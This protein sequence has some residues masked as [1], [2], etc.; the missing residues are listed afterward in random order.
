MSGTNGGNEGLRY[1]LQG[2][3][4][5]G[6][7]GFMSGPYCSMLLADMGAEVIK[8]EQPGTG[9]PRRSIHPFAY[10]EDGRRLAA[11]FWA[12]NRNK[13]SMTLNLRTD[14]GKKALVDLV[15]AS[16]V[17]VENLR[18]GA[19][20]K[21]GLGHEVLRKHNPR[22]VYAMISGFGRLEG[23]RGPYSDRPSFD[24]VAEAMGGIMHLV[25]PEDGPPMQTIMGMADLNAGLVTAYGIMAA[26]FQRERTKEGQVVDI[27]LYD[28]VVALNERPLV[29]YSF[30]GEVAH[31]GRERHLGPRGAFRCKGGYVAINVPTDEVWER[32][33]K[34]IGREDLI[35]HPDAI[36]GPTRARNKEFVQVAIEEWL[37]DKTREEA[38]ELL[39]KGG[40]PAGP[41]YT[42]EDQFRCPQLRAR[43]MLREV[44]DPV[45]G[46][47][48]MVRTPA[49]LSGTP[50]VSTNPP[51][52][53][54]E[55]TD[56]VLSEVL[57][58]GD[59]QI[60]EL[61]ESGAV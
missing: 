45:A 44:E 2:V 39:V 47:R 35:G 27:A 48:L 57:G 40:V 23:Y 25:G 28:S 26:L 7:E 1:P 32:L 20:E 46:K 6:L 51:P 58:Y 22:L 12:Y 11:G 34:A 36:D 21:L 4:V 15:G 33:A 52:T 3:R 56:A 55:H 8:V 31:R 37:V 10:N 19:M 29:S 5:I 17:V 30:A 50:E 43:K 41:V 54:G 61:R 60:A 49:R 18:P 14:L 16:D 9:D 42:V 24:I 13:K 59:A 53:L 38:T